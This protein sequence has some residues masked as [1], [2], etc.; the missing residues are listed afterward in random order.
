MS[1]FDV[2]EQRIS[3]DVKKQ[4]LLPNG[5]EKIYKKVSD[6]GDRDLQNSERNQ[7]YP[8]PRD[9]KKLEKVSK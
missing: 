7:K 1:D 8:K 2:A 9:P 4:L 5:A 6:I 3:D